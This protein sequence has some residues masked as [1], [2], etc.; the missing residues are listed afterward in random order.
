MLI[1]FEA[2]L[3]SLSL[4]FEFERR[5]EWRARDAQIIFGLDAVKIKNE[6]SGQ[7]SEQFQQSTTFFSIIKVKA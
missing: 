1:Q 3:L 2:V 7:S 5:R 6:M 4:S